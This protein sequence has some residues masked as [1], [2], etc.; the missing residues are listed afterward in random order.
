MNPTPN[1]SAIFNAALAQLKTIL[2]SFGLDAVATAAAVMFQRPSLL[3][4][5]ETEFNRVLKLLKRDI[6]LRREDPTIHEGIEIYIE[7]GGHAGTGG[8]C[9]RSILR[10]FRKSITSRHGLGFRTSQLTKAADPRQRV[11][12]LPCRGRGDVAAVLRRA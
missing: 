2:A 1:P 7:A 3:T 4:E 8:R 5:S 10:Q 6:A 11:Q 9:V 12:A